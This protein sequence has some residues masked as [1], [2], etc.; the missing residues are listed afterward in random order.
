MRGESNRVIPPNSS[1]PTHP[2]QLIRPN[3]S[4][5]AQC[6]L[7]GWGRHRLERLGDDVLAPDALN[8]ELWTEREPVCKRWD[9]DALHIFRHDEVASVECCLRTRELEERMKPM[10]IRRTC[11]RGKWLWEGLEFRSADEPQGGEF[12]FN[13][14]GDE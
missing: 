1:G 11:S 3:S 7:R 9:R 2:A 12:S 5:C 6:V 8:P 14:M 4:G 13:A 10:G